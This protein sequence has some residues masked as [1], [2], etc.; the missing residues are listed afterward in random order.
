MIPLKVY[1][2]VHSVY[3]VI[4]LKQSLCCGQLSLC[5]NST[6]S[7]RCGPLSLC[8]DSTQTFH[9]MVHSVSVVVPLKVYVMVHSVYVVVPLKVY[10]VVHPVCCGS[11]Q[12]MLW[13]TQTVYAPSHSS[14]FY[15]STETHRCSGTLKPVY[16]LVP[17][18]CPCCCGFCSTYLCCSPLSA[19][20]AV[21]ALKPVY[22]L[23]HKQQSSSHKHDKRNTIRS[24]E[25]LS[26]IR[27]SSGTGYKYVNGKVNY[28][29]QA[30]SSISHFF[31]CACIF[32]LMMVE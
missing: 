15:S 14:L 6:Q 22:I 9:V 27:P 5:C 17:L 2:V 1:V 3:V 18:K 24:F 21:T 19:V 8:C 32:Y 16:A 28:A 20:Y 23:I 11:T 26:L 31:L 10:V 29:T 30:A 12:S 25:F 13:S 7:L 4:Q